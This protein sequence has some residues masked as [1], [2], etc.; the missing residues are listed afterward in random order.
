MR[1]GK[2]PIGEMLKKRTRS[3]FILTFL[4][5][6]VF[7][8]SEGT[9]RQNAGR[10]PSL[11]S[12][13]ILKKAGDAYWNFL[14]EDG[15]SLRLQQGLRIEKFPDLSL[16]KAR[17]DS[18]FAASLLEELEKAKVEDLSHEESLSLQILDWELKNAVDGLKYY[19]LV[20][21]VTPYSSPLPVVHR[22][23]KTY[24]FKEKSDLDHY[25]NLLKRYPRFIGGI[26][27]KL[28]YQ[29]QK[30]LILPKDELRQVIPFLTSFSKRGEQSLFFVKTDRLKAFEDSPKKRFQQSLMEIID[31]EINPALKKLIDFIEGDYLAKAPGSV[32]IWQYP[33]GR[34]YYRYLIRLNTTL[35]L[36]PEDVQEIGLKHVRLIDGRLDEQRKALDFK[37]TPA[38]FRRFLR[39]DP[40]F[41]AKT[42]DEIKAKLT[43]YAEAM[44]KK[45]D[46][47]FLRMP[48]APY[49][50]E[51]LAP[52]LEASMTF[53]TYEAPSAYEPRGI[54]Y[55]NGSLVAERS[56]LWAEALIYHEL[57]P[58]HHYHLALQ[59]ENSSL[60]NF[61]RET[62][63]NAF[64]EGWAEYASW[65]GLDMGLYQD[66]L[67]LCG[68]Y[69][70]DMMFAVRLVVDSGMNYFE[71]PRDRAETYMAEHLVESETQIRSEALRYSTD[72]PG[73]ALGYKIGSLKMA[74]LR[75]KALKKLGKR[76]D[77]RKFNEALVGSGSMPFPV[78]EKHIDWFI[79]NELSSPRK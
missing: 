63:H 43:S 36:T 45:M 60:P 24:P 22:A 30:A 47:F 44:K 64:T 62:Y 6:F 69:Q 78:L 20:F 1:R 28:Q 48:K 29:F 10:A 37:G 61:R 67:S 57:I 8:T 23:F 18:S 66:P 50:I 72:M 54:Y 39:T 31:A 21:P 40:R 7:L 41:F 51:R 9:T 79:E 33:D 53:G 46:G 4:A 38:E 32:G 52:E 14:L 3:F 68:K 76:F 17:A 34:E 59:S 16:E 75:D 5:V 56:L 55:F 2:D 13:D 26:Q 73:Q 19:W 42:P 77:V 58:G 27:A 12:S 71:W 49:G 11:S 70:N 65:L 25:V 15:L 74:E 35:N